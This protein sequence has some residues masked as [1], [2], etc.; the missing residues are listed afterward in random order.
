MGAWM[1]LIGLT[2]LQGTLHLLRIVTLIWREREHARS[3]CLQIEA[4]AAAGVT[5]LD[6]RGRRAKLLIVSEPPESSIPKSQPGARLEPVGRCS[7]N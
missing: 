7:V 4:A 3:N 5:V 6:V 1:P 2:A